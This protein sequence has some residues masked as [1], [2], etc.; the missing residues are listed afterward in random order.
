MPVSIAPADEA[1]QVIVTRLNTGGAYTLPT[2]AEYFYEKSDDV[3][4]LNTLKVD[5]IHVDEQDLD[6]T[7]D[8]E[9]RTSHDI[10]VWIRKHVTGAITTA[11][12]A[13]IKLIGRQVFQRLN[14][15]GTSRV[16]VWDCGR[17]PEDGTDRRVKREN[18]VI[19]LMIPLRVEVEAS[20]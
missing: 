3:T 16:K 12:I 13:A 15:Y 2:A 6:D 18:G 9:S 4:R 8:I 17:D 14:N 20:A 5:V 11:E 7:L 10:E 19:S 1:C